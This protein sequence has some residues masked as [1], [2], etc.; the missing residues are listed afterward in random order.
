MK[1][2]EAEKKKQE[3]EEEEY[4]TTNTNEYYYQE[5]MSLAKKQYNIH[6]ILYNELIVDKN[7]QK[8]SQYKSLCQIQRDLYRTFPELKFFH[9]KDAP[10]YQPFLN[11][12]YAYIL[13]RP[14][15]GYVQG[16]SYLTAMLLL[17]VNEYDA[18]VVFAN[19]LET[20]L[21]RTFFTFNHKEMMIHLHTFDLLLHKYLPKIYLHF[22]QQHISSTMYLFEW[23]FTM[24]S[25]SLSLEIAHRIWDNYLYHGPAFLF[26]TS[27]GLIRLLKPLLLISNFEQILPLLQRPP[28]QIDIDELFYHI[29]KI[30]HH[31][32][33][34]KLLKK[35]LQKKKKKKKSLINHIQ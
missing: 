27:L 7:E 10:L 25:R 33:E 3:E 24:F 16:M 31:L 9:S 12:L 15:I 34:A 17:N 19:L 14:D 2:E 26:T 29:S 22:Q 21:Y 11:I 32:I 5:L 23:I 20:T 1:E 6:L 28:K 18:F 4:L 8:D 30:P 35:S 13:M